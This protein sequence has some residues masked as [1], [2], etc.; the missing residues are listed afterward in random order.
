MKNKKIQV[1]KLGQKLVNKRHKTVYTVRNI[2]ESSVVLVSEDGS[3]SLRV[4]VD[5][6]SPEEYDTLYD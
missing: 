3:K 2:E 1:I 4:P 5:S 6:I